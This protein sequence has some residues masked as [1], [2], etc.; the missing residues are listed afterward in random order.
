MLTILVIE[1]NYGDFVLMQE[2]LSDAF[3]E[4]IIE[5]SAD[6]TEAIPL[7]TYKKVDIVLAHLTPQEKED[8]SRLENFIQQVAHIPVVLIAGINEVKFAVQT[9]Q[10]GV[11]DYLTKDDLN[12][13]LLIKTIQFSLERIRFQLQLQKSEEQYKLLFQKTPLPMWMYDVETFRFL[14]VNEAAIQL[15]SYSESEFL[16]LT[17]LDIRPESEHQKFLQKATS[18]EAGVIKHA[19]KWNHRKK[20]HSIIAVNITTHDIELNGKSCRLAIITL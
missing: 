10:L 2:Y 5:K 9:L 8:L 20:D 1:D 12:P 17:L 13:K 14:Q 11:Q 6:L 19:G 15:Y 4:C 18:F 7:L 3:D 16:S